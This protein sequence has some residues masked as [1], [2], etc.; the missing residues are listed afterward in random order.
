MTPRERVD[1]AL[2][3]EMPDWVPFTVYECMLPTSETERRLRDD[4]LCIVVPHRRLQHG[5]AT[6][7]PRV[8]AL[9]G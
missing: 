6:S 7:A 3:N 5:A 4:G 2:R 8:A 1:A 9:Q